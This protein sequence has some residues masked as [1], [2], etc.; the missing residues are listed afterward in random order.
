MEFVPGFLQGI[1]RVLISYPFDYVRTHIQT[2]KYTGINDIIKNN[3][4]T[5]ARS[6][7]GC[8]LPLIGVS[9]DRSIQFY[10]FEKMLKNRPVLVSSCIV[11][12]LSSIY[13]IPLNLIT[14][15]IITNKRLKGINIYKGSLP[16]LSKNFLGTF[17]YTSTYGYL[18]TNVAL[19]KHNYFLFGIISSLSS[20][21]I[22]YPFDTVRV[23]YQCNNISYKNIYNTYTF[24]GLY[25]GFPLVVL[26]SVPSA[27][28]GMLVYEKSRKYLL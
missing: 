2:H 19:N 12:L 8:T 17:V 18:R 20:W 25:K 11:A 15:L 9:I 3:N 5:L 6:Y 24:R 26:R 4:L 10:L 1:T 28:I 7:K 23:L 21:S 22:I 16:D 14:T 13:S 27:G